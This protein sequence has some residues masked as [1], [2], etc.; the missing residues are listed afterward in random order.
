MPIAKAQDRW[1]ET[2]HQ[3]RGTTR[4]SMGTM[5]WTAH[6]LERVERQFQPDD[7][8]KDR[9]H[10]RPTGLLRSTGWILAV[11]GVALFVALPIYK[12]ENDTPLLLVGFLFVTALLG[13]GTYMLLEADRREH[14]WIYLENAAHPGLQQHISFLTEHA[15]RDFQ[16]RKAP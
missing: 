15:V 3:E 4:S 2:R 8:I 12:M 6:L 16:L 9:P 5:R 14:S 10:P 7:P 13:T 1:S 11:L